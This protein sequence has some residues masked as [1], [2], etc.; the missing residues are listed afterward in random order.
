L[1]E[2]GHLSLASAYKALNTLAFIEYLHIV[3]REWD[4]IPDI[5]ITS[6]DIIHMSCK[7]CP[8]ILID[9]MR[10]IRTRPF[11]RNLV[12][13]DLKS[14]TILAL[15]QFRNKLHRQFMHNRAGWTECGWGAVPRH[16]LP[17][18]LFLR[19]RCC[20]LVAL[21]GSDRSWSPH[22]SFALHG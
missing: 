22:P 18:L 19:H 14:A 12:L 2:Q 3:K 4:T 15:S 21:H 17:V 13:R 10:H 1:R 8:L 16:S 20:I 6:Q 5:R 7:L 9:S 11:D